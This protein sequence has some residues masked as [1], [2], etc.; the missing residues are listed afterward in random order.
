[1]QAVSPRPYHSAGRQAAS[2]ETRAQI[3]EAAWTL[4]GDKE[5]VPLTVDAIAE[6]ANVARMTVY[7][8]FGTKRGLV[9]A[10]SDEVAA[11]GGIAR[12]PQAFQAKSAAAGLEIL[13]RVFIG[14][15]ESE[16][17]ALR[18]LRAVA[19][20]DPELAGANRDLRRRQAIGVVLRRLAT[21]T[22]RPAAADMERTID[23][24]WALTAFDTYE[25]L[26]SVGR[27]ARETADLIIAA[28]RRQLGLEGARAA[29]RP[30]GRRNRT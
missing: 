7:N 4:L 21:E 22:G 16:R 28:A 2:A 29:P 17:L 1:M 14:F 23:L 26:A 27:S 3:L 5:P 18:R 13:I 19:A 12:L 20:L 9:E 8:Q 6:R 30:P 24:L 15:W 25:Q 10:L 11:R